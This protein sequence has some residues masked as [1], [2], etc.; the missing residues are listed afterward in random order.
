M[1][2]GT[3]I[4]GEHVFCRFVTLSKSNLWDVAIWLPALQALVMLESFEEQ[5]KVEP[6]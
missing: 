2:A 4:S 6:T 1:G 3:G 5:S